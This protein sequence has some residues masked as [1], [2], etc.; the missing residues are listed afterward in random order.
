MSQIKLSVVLPVFNEEGNLSVIY[1]EMRVVCTELACTYEIIFVDDGSLDGSLNTL[2]EIQQKDSN[3]RVIQFRRNFGQTAALAAGFAIARGQVIVTLDA[4]CQ[5]D[6]KD[7]PIMLKKLEEGYDL[8]CGWRYRRQDNYFSRTLPSKIAN[9]IIG[10]LTDIKLHDYG[11]TLK[12]M[13]SDLAK[14][15]KLYGEM[16]RLIPALSSSYG[17]RI[18]EVKVNHRPRVSGL[19]K[20]GL[21]RTLRV[22]LDVITVKFFLS[23]SSRPIQLFGSFGLISV[24]GGVSILG[25]YGVRKIFFGMSLAD[26]PVLLL[27]VLLIIGG[28]QFITFGLLAE[29][30]IRTYHESQD[31]PTYLIRTIYESLE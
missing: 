3:V 8:V 2:R 17:A 15:L 6:P 1:E 23:F 4:D 14:S 24:L 18:S 16:H 20:Y 5:N 7:I 26:R 27:A 10:L 21:S 31:K 22:V 28:L 29:L 9:F 25:V 19:S 11:C 13:R 12:V 30:Q